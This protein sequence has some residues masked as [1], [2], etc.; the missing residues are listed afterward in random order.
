M[1]E[2]AKEAVRAS[3]LAKSDSDKELTNKL[4][5]LTWDCICVIAAGCE[6]GIEEAEGGRE[7]EGLLRCFEEPFD[8]KD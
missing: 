2:G 6:E 7:A 5:E 1:E 3:I 8:F 4:R